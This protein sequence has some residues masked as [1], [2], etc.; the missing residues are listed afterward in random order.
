[1]EESFPFV[2]FLSSDKKVETLMEIFGSRVNIEILSQFCGKEGNI[3]KVPQKRIIK[4][5][6]YSNKTIIEHLNTLV[7]M[8]ILKESMVKE[9]GRWM[10]IFEIEP[11]N[12][13]LI[14]LICD[15]KDIPADK[16]EYL[17]NEFLKDY[18]N[19]VFEI[20]ERLGFDE[21]KLAET[22]EGLIDERIRIRK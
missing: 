6:R 16:I 13:W 5:L 12:S 19:K 18:V 7:N 15:L 10:K 4:N 11:S 2:V 14:W 17:L 8:N 22:L 3:E 21:K 9:G 20:A 1:M